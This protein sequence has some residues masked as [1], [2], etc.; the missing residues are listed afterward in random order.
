MTEN[1]IQPKCSRGRP[2][3]YN[4]DEDNRLSY[5]R[6]IKECMLR[7]PSHCGICDHTYYMSSKSNN[8]RSNK[9]MKSLNN[10]Q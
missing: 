7:N 2:K 3:K 1:V 8:L 10:A 4:N 9:H 5:N 6:Q